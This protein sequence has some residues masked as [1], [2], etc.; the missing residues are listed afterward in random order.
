MRINWNIVKF[1]F[2]TVLFAVTILMLFGVN[3]EGSPLRYSFSEASQLLQALS[4][5][6]ISVEITGL[7]DVQSNPIP[8]W[9]FEE[10]I[11]EAKQLVEASQLKL[12]VGA[13]DLVYYENRITLD[14]N[15]KVRVINK[16]LT[17]P[18][19]EIA[20]VLIN[21]ETGELDLIKITERG[22][23]IIVP[24]GYEIESVTRPNGITSNAWNTQRKVIKPENHAVILNV[25]P[26]FVTKKIPKII[27]DKQGRKKTIYINEKTIEHRIYSPFSVDIAVPE[28]VY[29]GKNYRQEL[30][31]KARDSLRRQKVRSRAYPDKLLVDVEILKPEF[32][33]RLPL[34]EQADYREFTLN[35]TASFERIDVIIGA[36]KETAYAFT[37]SRAKACGLLQ[38][39]KGTYNDMRKKYPAAQL[40]SDFEAGYK[41][42]ANLMVAAMLL[43]DNNL[44]SLIK[45]FGEV[46]I[47]KLIEQYGE[48]FIE[49]MLAA[50][51]N[52]GT[53]R[54]YRSLRAS[55]LKSLADW[56]TSYLRPETRQY[57]DKLRYVRENYD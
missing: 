55:I 28:L 18:E 41:D 2:G 5:R 8:S 43:H 39:T 45:E 24:T 47:V 33:E 36:N 19:R 35:P 46:K 38:Y 26:H 52:G 1:V 17:D 27:K 37:C 54:P 7:P 30:V 25:W 31:Q 22:G 9:T 44:A 49:E 12:K 4:S 6:A 42:P 16:R 15:G 50:N 21:L 53:V 13:K 11:E 20:L 51:Y 3:S 57:I 48:D 10:K 32:F 23:H 29:E 34:I 56:I 40:H 14:S